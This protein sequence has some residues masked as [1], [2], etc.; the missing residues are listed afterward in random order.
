MKI[1]RTDFDFLNTIEV[2]FAEGRNFS[3]DFPSDSAAIV[4]NES[5]VAQ[6]G[7]KESMER[8]MELSGRRYTV[9]GIVKDFH[10]ESLHRKIPPTIFILSGDWLNWVYIRIDNRDVHAALDHIEKTYSKYVT[11]RD[12]TYTFVDED[13]KQQYVAEEKFSETFTICT[14]LAIVI[15]CLGT[16]GLISF[17]AERR[18]KEIGI[19][20]VLGA[21]VGNVS[22]LLIREFIIL[23]FIASAIGLPITWYFLNN[24][25]ETFV[26]RTSIGYDPFALAII[27][28]AI[29][30]VSTTGFRAVKAALTNPVNSLRNE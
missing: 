6:L 15:A 1:I 22:F 7:W 8:W 16:F 28:S 27:L 11:N 2:E 10:F 4:L 3:L 13:I 17:S 21:S 26:Y 29:I 18:A 5:A 25:M 9:V 30:V 19:R 23:L 20:K 24:W 14:S 12:F